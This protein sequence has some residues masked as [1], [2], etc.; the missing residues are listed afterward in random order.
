M[1]EITYIWGCEICFGVSVR[2]MQGGV[3]WAMV[4]AVEGQG[5][6]DVKF[7]PNLSIFTDSEGIFH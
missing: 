1:E 4:M 2:C 6:A 5:R 3:V 7:M